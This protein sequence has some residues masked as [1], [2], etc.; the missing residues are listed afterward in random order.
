M[1]MDV[2]SW[3]FR[4]WVPHH[5]WLAVAP[6]VLCLLAAG[7]AWLRLRRRYL[8][9]VAGLRAETIASGVTV[10]LLLATCVTALCAVELV[11]I[12]AW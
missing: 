11:A 1:G 6:A 7:A 2:C 10:N 12:L 3:F 9:H 8:G 4:R 5:R